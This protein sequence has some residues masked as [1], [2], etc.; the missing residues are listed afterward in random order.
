MDALVQRIPRL[1]DIRRLEG[2]PRI[3]MTIAKTASGPS[4][5]QDQG[6]ESENLKNRAESKSDPTRVTRVSVLSSTSTAKLRPDGC[7]HGDRH[8]VRLDCPRYERGMR[9]AKK[10]RDML[11]LAR[12]QNRGAPPTCTITA[13][14]Y[15]LQQS[16]RQ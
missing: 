1:K 8:Q 16:Q 3:V 9:K 15:Q 4:G 14:P 10:E 2:Y 5:V 7:P 6:Q 11:F 12:E 13:M